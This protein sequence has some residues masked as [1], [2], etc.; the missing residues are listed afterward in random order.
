MGRAVAVLSLALGLAIAVTANVAYA[1]PRGPVVIGVGLVAPL[2]LPV[3]LYL[4]TLFDVADWKHWLSR[5]VATLAVAG[6]AVA[7]SYWHTFALVLDAGEPI[8]L[9]LLVPLSSDGLAGMATLALHRLRQDVPQASLRTAVVADLV[10]SRD[11]PPA[12]VGPAKD[13]P[14]EHP[15]DVRDDPSRPVHDPSPGTSQDSSPGPV[16]TRSA[17]TSREERLRVADLRRWIG[18]RQGD[19]PSPYAVRKRIGCSQR[20]AERLLSLAAEEPRMTV[21]S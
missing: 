11:V 17:P 12:T 16:P 7:V 2:V 19:V 10:A 21:V 14:K 8:A 1:I 4:R 6:P 5:E 9:A 15:R 18:E 20:T 13:V 3:V